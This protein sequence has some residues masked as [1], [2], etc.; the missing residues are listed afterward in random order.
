MITEK[1]NTYIVPNHLKESKKKKAPHCGRTAIR[2]TLI[3]SG[4]I[5]GVWG[6]LRGPRP[7]LLMQF[8]NTKC[9]VKIFSF[10]FSKRPTWRFFEVVYIKKRPIQMIISP[11]MHTKYSLYALGNPHCNVFFFFYQ[12][13]VLDFKIL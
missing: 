2:G 1:K 13:L 12:P 6:L 10:F 11:L 7:A 8:R 5:G 4:W 3:H 9:W